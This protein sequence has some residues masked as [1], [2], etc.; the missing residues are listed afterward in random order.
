MAALFDLEIEQMDAI[1]AFLN[2]KIDGDVYCELPPSYSARG[3]NY[4]NKEYVCKL[5]KALYGLKQSPRLW[6]ETL[7]RALAEPGPPV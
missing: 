7:R 5:R 2:G 3:V 6:Q 4:S 1:A